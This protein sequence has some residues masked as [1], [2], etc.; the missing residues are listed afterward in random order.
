MVVLS[1]ACAAFDQFKN[2]MERGQAFKRAGPG[3]SERRAQ[4]RNIGWTH[5]KTLAGLCALPGPSGFEGP[6]GPGG[7]WSCSAP[8][9]TRRFVDRMGSV[10]GVRPLR[11]GGGRRGAAGRPS[12]RDRLCHH[13]T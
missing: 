7:G 11:P 8:W 9:W 12:G 6:G 10:V 4:R 3:P 2:F 5:D 1:P 13:R